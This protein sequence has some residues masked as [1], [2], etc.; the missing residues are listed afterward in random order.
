MEY[1]W[2][3][4]I[5]ISKDYNCIPSGD[6]SLFTRKHCTCHPELD[7]VLF[8]NIFIIRGALKENEDLI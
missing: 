2:E 3:K 7:S 8:Q 4:I 6:Y 1:L 5:K